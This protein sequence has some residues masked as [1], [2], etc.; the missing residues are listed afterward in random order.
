MARDG[1]HTVT[2]SWALVA[3]VASSALALVLPLLVGTAVEGAGTGV[4]LV[5][6]VALVVA[7]LLAA[8]RRYVVFAARPVTVRAGLSSAPH[9]QLSGNVT[10]PPHHPV[11]PRAPGPA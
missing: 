8:D 6:L 7:V 9:V 3:G 5:A 11:R 1:S 4:A 2:P 10:D